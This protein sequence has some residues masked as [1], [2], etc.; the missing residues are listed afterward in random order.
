[1]IIVVL[2]LYIDETKI[3]I[4][5]HYRH[6]HAL[7]SKWLL[8]LFFIVNVTPY[9]T[10]V[11]TYRTCSSGPTTFSRKWNTQKCN[12]KW[13]P[14]GG[15][16]WAPTSIDIKVPNRFKYRRN[17]PFTT[18]VFMFY[19]AVPNRFKYHQNACLRDINC[20]HFS[21]VPIHF[22]NRQASECIL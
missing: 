22:N 9:H 18:L 5:K 21:A 14:R 6:T 20:F 4:I 11:A 2:L 15:D 12:K 13:R 1:M 19:S 10:G 3:K 17:A 8:E 16:E 7:C